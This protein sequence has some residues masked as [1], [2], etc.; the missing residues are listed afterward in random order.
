MFSWQSVFCSFC[1]FVLPL[2]TAALY[3]M[4]ETQ[5]EREAV[6][7]VSIPF[8]P[9]SPVSPTVTLGLHFR[10]AQ[11]GIRAFVV[12]C[13]E[14]LNSHQDFLDHLT[15]SPNFRTVTS[16][17]DSNVIIAFVLFD[18]QAGIDIEATR[19]KIRAISAT[20]PIIFV[21]VHFT[22]DQRLLSCR[23]NQTLKAMREYL[24]LEDGRPPMQWPWQLLFWTPVLLSSILIYC[25]S[26]PKYKPLGL[27]LGCSI[28]WW[29][30]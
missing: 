12:T 22:A 2:P 17:N 7:C 3:T 30:S 29:F 10:M 28:F 25:F 18:S 13:G 21:M 1:P 8:N 11:D 6:F 26:A 4:T 9:R 24:G 16:V 27:F 23:N 19:Q 5:A 15:L 20:Q 14:T